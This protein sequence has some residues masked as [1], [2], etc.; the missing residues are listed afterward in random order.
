M[1]TP[2]KLILV[3][4]N[5]HLRDEMVDFLTQGDW[6]A[7]GVD[8]G[9]ELNEWLQSNTPDIAI[10]DVNLPYEDG[11]SIA[12]RLRAA[13]PKLGIVMLTGRFRQSERSLGY[14]SGA[15]VYLSKPTQPNELTAVIENLARRLTPPTVSHYVLNRNTLMLQSPH[16]ATCQLSAQEAAVVMQLILASA[17]IASKDQLIEALTGGDGRP[18]SVEALAVLI[19]R[20]RQK[21]KQSLDLDALVVTQRGVGYA[22]AVPVRLAD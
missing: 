20:L 9:E 3:E 18:Y 6:Q 21:C 2:L 15:D 5:E 8:C 7:F 14:R 1:S 17:R 10:L 4:D 19:S 22:L 11:Y 12:E 13:Y 16:G